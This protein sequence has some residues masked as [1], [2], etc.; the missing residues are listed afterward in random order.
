[1]TH[2]L[3]ASK[4]SY[5]TFFIGCLVHYQLRRATLSWHPIPH[6]I[7]SLAKLTINVVS[8]L[9]TQPYFIKY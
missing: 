7:H 6:V 1:M 5:G 3:V 2:F 8:I 4:V 9:L